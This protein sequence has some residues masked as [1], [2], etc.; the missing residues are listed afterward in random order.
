VALLAR[1]AQAVTPPT[2]QTPRCDYCGQPTTANDPNPYHWY[3]CDTQAN[4]SSGIAHCGQ[5]GA[6]AEYG[7]TLAHWDGCPS[8]T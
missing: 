7:D 4:P 1:I 5:C 2:V 3:G 8:L 6:M